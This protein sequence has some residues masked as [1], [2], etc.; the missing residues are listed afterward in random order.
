MDHQLRTVFWLTEKEAFYLPRYAPDFWAFRHRTVEFMDTPDADR[1][2]KHADKLAWR[3]WQGAMSTDAR[4]FTEDTAAKIAYR[5]R[6]LAELPD[7]PETTATRFDLLYT[8]AP[9]Y[10][11]QGE[12]EKAIAA[13]Q[14]AIALD[15]KDASPHHGLGNVYADLGRTDDAIAAYQQAIALDPKNAL[16]HNGLGIVY[17]QLGRTDDAIASFQQ[18]IE[19]DPKFA[20]P[21]N[22]LGNVYRQ[23]GRTDEAIVA[24]QQAIK[25]D[26]KDT[27]SH[28]GLGIVYAELGHTDKATVAFQRAIELDP[29]YNGSYLNLAIVSINQGQAEVALTYLQEGLAL[30]PQKRQW[31]ANHPNF[32]ALRDDPRFQALVGGSQTS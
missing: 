5:E 25:L 21:H 18:A 8:L 20:A 11:A 9:L 32:E 31:A 19:L 27:L 6:M 30:V 2:R 26:P 17:R 22:R 3:D 23:L 24:Y 28:N 10:A 4:A 14:Q 1:I 16:P 29:K 7:T 12:Y 13:C 15:P